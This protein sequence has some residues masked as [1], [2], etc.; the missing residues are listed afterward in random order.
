MQKPHAK[1]LDQY[2]YELPEE[3]IAHEP[4]EPRDASKLLVY[5][6]EKNEIV[7]T[8][9]AEIA[10]YIPEQSL[11]VMN[12]TRVLPVRVMMTKD[13]GGKVEVLFLTN[14][15]KAGSTTIKG[16]VDRK[17]VVGSEV[18]FGGQK[19]EKQSQ[20][21]LGLKVV[22]QNEHIFEFELS[23]SYAGF[24]E[25]LQKY[26]VMP[27]PRYIQSSLSEEKIRERYQT[28][29]ASHAEHAQASVAAPT[30]SLHF[31]EKVFESLVAKNISR[32]YVTLN[33]GQGTFATV[34][35]QQVQDRA[36]HEEWF[37]IPSTTARVITK[38]H[39]AN[40][41]VIAVGTTA[42]RTLESAGNN[43][44]TLSGSTRLFIQPGYHFTHVNGLITNFHLP[45]TSLMSLV[46]AFLKDRGS[47]RT[48]LDL[49]QHA[50]DHKYRF[51]SFGDAMLLV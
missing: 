49:Y 23:G 38:T 37:S 21:K 20:E 13:T 10:K 43:F 11:L 6:I 19:D 42:A 51:Y 47:K 39:A 33:V 3:L 45:N 2:S 16:M 25:L 24:C 50:I 22:G 44:E 18:F 17:V 40:H 32:E 5:N 12:D 36:L 31:T 15:Y 7:D 26:G 9:F 27:L 35:E 28:V 34:T 8:T 29:Y 30:A 4:V 46:D 1:F 14:E 41:K 48:I